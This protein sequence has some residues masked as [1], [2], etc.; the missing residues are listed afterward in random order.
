MRWKARYSIRSMFGLLTVSAVV[1]GVWFAPTSYDIRYDTSGWQQ[2][3]RDRTEVTQIGNPITII[4]VDDAHSTTVIVKDATV[5][6]ITL[7]DDY[8]VTIRVRVNVW[9]KI[10]LS[11]YRNK[12]WIDTAILRGGPIYPS[13]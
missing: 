8:I 1:A 13:R 7:N 3:D 2:F 4:T 11:R 12:T 6:G 9:Q 5:L 10:S